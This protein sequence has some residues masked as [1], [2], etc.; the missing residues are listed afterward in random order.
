[1]KTRKR[2]TPQP[3]PVSPIPDDF[4]NRLVATIGSLDPLNPRYSY[5]GVEMLSKFVSKDTDP[6]NVR[7][8]RAINKWLA[9]ER[10]NEATNDRLL[11][12][13]GEYNILP[14]ITVDSIVTKASSIIQKVLGDVPP[15][16]VLLGAFSGGSTTS[17]R[18]LDSHPA[19]KY[20]GQADITVGA[21]DW[22]DLVL[23]ES[24]LWSAYANE[25]QTVRVCRGNIM[26]T[27]PKNTQIDRCACKE[28]DLNMYIQKGIG[29]HI[30]RRLR[31]VGIN[32][33]DQSINKGLARLGSENHELATLD[34]SSAS[35]SIS[36]ELVALLLPDLWFSLLNAVRSKET[37]IDGEWHKNE[38]FS[39]MGNGFTFELES[40]L[41]FA[42]AKAV[43]WATG[44]SGIIS[45]YGDD[46]IVPTY[47]AHDLIWVLDYFGF[48]VNTKKSC[49]E[50]PIRESCG[51]HYYNG[52]DITPFYVKAPLQTLS[53]VIHLANQIR[54]W[55]D[56]GGHVILDDALEPLWVELTALVPRNLWG[57][58]D[59]SDKSRLVTYWAPRRPARL[60][61]RTQEIPTL[62]G[63][64]LMW[65]D[66]RG[67]SDLPLEV[68]SKRKQNL[69]RFT[70]KSV[71]A[72]L[73]GR[74]GNI[75]LTE[76]GTRSGGEE[77]LQSG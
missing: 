69:K 60:V 6:P 55:S 7:R 12:L 25:Y 67:D 68:V 39:S 30:R 36:Y 45:V 5:L 54:R 14:R 37:L 65:H 17:R 40:L 31:T 34:L 43:A 71:N 73:Y 47:M 3:G 48:E 44:I 52:R 50:G 11:T 18:R 53:D 13:C 10:N 49:I 51:G 9:T 32:L 42:I 66:S 28:P 23:E 8:Q 29:N 24:P 16:D 4:I 59:T 20:L 46:L 35:D 41:F 33:N 64:Y 58:H 19:G 56:D 38:M 27:V 15:L 1:M 77:P 75:F 22:W 2:S 63:G 62:L 26:F 57:G 61:E 70:F 74:P 21:K 76:L 72:A